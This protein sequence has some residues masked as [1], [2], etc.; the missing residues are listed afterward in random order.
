MTKEQVMS[1][2]KRSGVVLIA[3]AAVMSLALA[4]CAKQTAAE[5]E[6]GSSPAASGG[7]SSSASAA[8]EGQ[9]GAV[10]LAD[11]TVALVS[12]GAHPYFQPWKQAGQ[13]AVAD[14]GI[15][16]ATFNEAGEWDQ[17]KQTTAIEGL[18]AQ[19]YTAFGV[20]GVSATDINSNFQALKDQGFSVGSLASCPAGDV[21]KADFCLS[22]D[23]ELAAYKS[24]TGVIEAMGGTGNLVHLTGSPVDTN[25]QRRI[26]GVQRAVD[27]TNGK[28]KLLTTITD[29]EDDLLS[30]QK[31]VTDLL[32]TQGN[33]IQGIVSS[34]YN[35][36][37]AATQG[38]I[39]SGLPI[40]FV[41]TD[42]DKSVLDAIAAGKIDGTVLQNPYG[43]GYIGTWALA[44]LKSGACTMKTPGVVVDSGSF[45]VTKANVDTYEDE[46]TAKT[47]EILK[48]FQG[49][50]L[51]CK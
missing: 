46:R 44:N 32:A 7:E 15:G 2:Q 8:D 18:A 28:V 43:Q 51:D 47:K 4:G 30:G 14:F 22:T 9:S 40:R 17:S 12:G 49:E 3:T 29:V 31:A 20:F 19:G 16:G 11:V 5:N 1:V 37:V 41:G 50:L 21:N 42:N 34:G 24:A 27:E 36:S 48:Q 33:D 35:S 26:Q 38:I 39:E 13:D 6:G 23:T 45:L 25:T 10:S